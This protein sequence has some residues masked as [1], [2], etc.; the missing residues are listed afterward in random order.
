MCYI[1]FYSENKFIVKDSSFPAFISLLFPYQFS[2]SIFCISTASEF[3][4]IHNNKKKVL[5]KHSKELFI[6]GI[7][8]WGGK[9]CYWCNPWWQY[10]IQCAIDNIYGCTNRNFFIEKNC[11]WW[12][13]VRIIITSITR[14]HWV[15]PKLSMP[16][17]V[18]RLPCV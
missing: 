9:E 14:R 12:T 15:L 18:I 11:F 10:A 17:P 7:K 6:L 13:V 5:D 2:S 1:L 3:L 16:V 4:N 8:L